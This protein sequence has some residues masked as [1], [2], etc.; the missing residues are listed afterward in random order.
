MSKFRKIIIAGSLILCGVFFALYTGFAQTITSVTCDT[1]YYFDTAYNRCVLSGTNSPDSSSGSGTSTACATGYQYDTIQS[2]CVSATTTIV[3]TIVNTA[4]TLTTPLPLPVI[5]FSATTLETYVG[6]SVALSWK[7]GNANECAARDGWSGSRGISGTLETKVNYTTTFTL[8][9]T[10]S[11]GSSSKSVIVVARPIPIC[12]IGHVFSV[13][14]GMCVLD[15]NNCATGTTWSATTN[16]CVTPKIP[17]TCNIGFYYD[18]AYD[19]CMPTTTTIQEGLSQTPLNFIS[20]SSPSQVNTVAYTWVFVDGDMSS[21][22]FNRTDLEYRSYLSKVNTACKNFS[23]EKFM[24]M[25]DYTNNN[26]DN[27]RSFGI[28]RCLPDST[29]TQPIVQ[30][31]EKIIQDPQQNVIDLPGDMTTQKVT[32][33]M[34]ISTR[35]GSVFEGGVVFE[36]AQIKIGVSL[37]ADE[38]R[39]LVMNEK[40]KQIFDGVDGPVRTESPTDWMFGWDTTKTPNGTYKVVAEAVINGAAFDIAGLTVVVS[41]NI[42]TT[43]MPIKKIDPKVLLPVKE[44]TYQTCNSKEECLKLCSI[45]SER[46]EICKK[47][48]MEIIVKEEPIRSITQTAKEDKLEQVLQKTREDGVVAPGGMKKLDDLHAYCSNPKNDVECK[49]FLVKEKIVDEKVVVEKEKVL[50]EQ[51]QEMKRVITERVGARMFEDGDSDGI[52]DY[53]ENNLYRTDPKRADSDKDGIKD[54]EELLMGTDPL[55]FD[56]KEPIVEKPIA[57]SPSS[58]GKPADKQPAIAIVEPVFNVSSTT[59][60]TKGRIAYENPKVV[61]SEDATVLIAQKVNVVEKTTDTSGKEKIKKM[62]FKGKALPNSFVTV[63]VFSTPI[64]VTVKTDA[65]GN[66]SYVLDKELEDGKHEVYVAMTDGGGKIVAK[67]SPLPFVKEA[68]AVT[69]DITPVSI[70]ET[71][72]PSMMDQTYLIMI[73]LLIVLIIGGALVLSVAKSSS[74]G[75]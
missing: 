22:I 63:Y 1:G 44:Q 21:K 49:N 50:K 73:G 25:P 32:G 60:M 31:I 45:S 37:K 62:E 6:Q 36:K 3:N 51:R 7:A 18:S 26:A 38:M 52:S 16:T 70:I 46:M 55:V 13:T 40:S 57:A 75:E 9:C 65:N 69:T 43:L 72:K 30:P 24:W 34:A 2:K 53:D 47:F 12:S 8:A 66:W 56:K 67:S 33:K 27:W 20:T 74:R 41:N 61:G 10:G 59:I 68:A 71:V 23:R 17:M 19:T 5:S 64:V 42:D 35:K 54:G 39:V 14:Q 4:N 58:P 28:P 15:P 11:G 48:Q 29:T